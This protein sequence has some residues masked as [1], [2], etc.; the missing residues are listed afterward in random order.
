MAGEGAGAGAGAASDAV[1]I[2]HKLIFDAVNEELARLA[3][4]RRGAEAVPAYAR[5]LGRAGGGGGGRGPTT[6]G[7]LLAALVASIG[8]AAGPGP[9]AEETPD[10]VEA[11]VR[12]HARVPARRWGHF[13]EEDEAVV[14]TL[15]ANEVMEELLADTALEVA[16]VLS[17]RREQW[18]A[19]AAAATGGAGR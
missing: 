11:L 2:R 7:A 4:P 12:A 1:A 19:A 8:G 9:E 10:R 3:G 16:I 15:V 14:K 17:E 5:R 13:A 6:R 18:A